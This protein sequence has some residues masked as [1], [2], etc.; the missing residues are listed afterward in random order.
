ML[1]HKHVQCSHWDDNQISVPAQQTLLIF[2]VANIFIFQPR[3]CVLFD[4]C[5]FH[6]EKL[7]CV[8]S[9]PRCGGK[10]VEMISQFALSDDSKS[11]LTYYYYYY[12][13][14]G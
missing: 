1:S 7:H 3:L 2:I 6:C 8:F 13:Q 10:N 12:L 9:L 11:W 5:L 4:L 14:L